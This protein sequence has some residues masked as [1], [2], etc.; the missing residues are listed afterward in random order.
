MVIHAILSHQIQM[1]HIRQKG[2]TFQI[3]CYWGCVPFFRNSSKYFYQL[4]LI[5]EKEKKKARKKETQSHV[6]NIH[7]KSSEKPLP[8]FFFWKKK[9]T[10]GMCVMYIRI[11]N[12][13]KKVRKTSHSAMICILTVANTLVY[14]CKLIGN[15]SQQKSWKF[16]IQSPQTSQIQDQA[17][18]SLL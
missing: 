3:S 12:N 1:H 14:M 15:Q 8:T 11:F 9:K 17:S 7:T 5:K 4:L 16:E 6:Q 2:T 18:A 13:L 10:L